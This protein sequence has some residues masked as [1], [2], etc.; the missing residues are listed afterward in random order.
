MIG[1][2]SRGG[3]LNFSN[4]SKI[5]IALDGSE[6]DKWPRPSDTLPKVD[7][8]ASRPSA[9]PFGHDLYFVFF[10]FFGLNDTNIYRRIKRFRSRFGLVTITKCGYDLE[11]CSLNLLVGW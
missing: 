11:K 1:H 4:C 5:D 7:H 2:F 6:V 8:L 9:I 3:T 10:L